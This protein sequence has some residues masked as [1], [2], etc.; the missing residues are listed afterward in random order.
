[1][2]RAGGD[3]P[4][5]E[6]VATLERGAAADDARLA[7]DALELVG[8]AAVALPFAPLPVAT[9]TAFRG[10]ARLV[11]QAVALLGALAAD[12]GAPALT[13]LLLARSGYQ[14]LLDVRAWRTP[15]LEGIHL[16]RTDAALVALVR[17]AGSEAPARPRGAPAT[18]TW[19]PGG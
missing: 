16:Q 4:A 18:H 7:V 17:T 12:D 10:E 13:H 15:P 6:A 14:A 19:W 11:A 9:V 3:A 2:T 8:R 1:M 5:V